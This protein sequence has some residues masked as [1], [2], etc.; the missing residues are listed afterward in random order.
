MAFS[1]AW[2]AAAAEEEEKKRREA[3]LAAEEETMTGYTQG[4][5]EGEWEFKI[6][7]SESKA[8][9]RPEVLN[10]LIE[11]EAQAGWVLLEKLDD[12]RI[13]FKRPR[14]ARARDVYL[15]EGIDPYRTQYGARSSQAATVL[16]MIGLLMLTGFGFSA[17]FLLGEGLPRATI[18]WTLVAG[19]GLFVLTVGFVVVTLVRRGRR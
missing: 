2:I 18:M 5:L 19:V 10:R 7:R 16:T 15:P 1:G 12:G 17:M 8:F 9:R 13:R 11:E 6:V 4:E 3:L 14:R